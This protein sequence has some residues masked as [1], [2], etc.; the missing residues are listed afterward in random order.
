MLYNDSYARGIGNEH[1]HLLGRSAREHWG[2]LWDDARP[3]LDSVYERG[4]TISTRE[5][6]FSPERSGSPEFVSCDTTYSPVRDEDG[7]IAG[8]LCIINE[9]RER[10]QSEARQRQ[11]EAI[12]RESEEKY[13]TK[14]DIEQLE[15]LE[16]QKNVFLGVVS[17]ELKTPVTSAQAFSEVLEQRF[18]RAGD[19]KN[20]VL[21]GKIRVQMNK[22]TLL[23]RDLLDLSR[24]DAGKLQFHEESFPF[25]AL[26]DDI[27]EEVQ[28][29]TTTHHI[30]GEGETS[31]T[32]FG[33]REHIGQVLTNL[34]TNAVKYSPDATKV[35]VTISHTQHEVMLCVQDFGIGI[36]RD[37]L[38]HVFERFFRETGAQEE[39]FPGLGLGLY[40][41]A[42]FIRQ[43]C[44]TIWATSDKGSGSTFCFRLPL[45]RARSDHP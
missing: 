40:I 25:D 1:P 28:S 11:A 13:R 15:Q 14:T 20:A 3:L 7:A 44:G 31:A 38:P 10:V 18:R 16:Q 26:V 24:F 4:Q 43:Q 34:L 41:A 17:H 21:L 37:R 19:E 27:I 29:T 6:P 32:I 35:I 39:T 42:E 8:I 12:L 23:I 36:A 9:A 5:C 30:Q 45:Q 22:L 2:E 33:D